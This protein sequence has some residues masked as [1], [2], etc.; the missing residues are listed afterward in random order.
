[1]VSWQILSIFQLLAHPHYCISPQNRQR[2]H[3]IRLD[4]HHIYVRQSQSV[5]LTTSDS[6]VGQPFA[7]MF[8]NARNNQRCQGCRGKIE[9]GQPSPGDLVLQHKEHVLFQNPRTGSWQMS[10]DLRNT[11]YHPRM[12][13]IAP[14]H[15]DFTFSEIQV[16]DDVRERL[17]M[18]RTHVS[19]LNGKFGLV[20]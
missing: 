20:L 4:F 9:Q 6:S 14:R 3:P 12:G 1:M 19:H 16:R 13:C 10:K 17:I 8:Q 15:P 5:H 2:A 11:Y 18:N 7:V